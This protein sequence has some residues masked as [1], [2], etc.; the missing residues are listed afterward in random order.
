MA[1]YG[2]CRKCPNWVE[3]FSLFD[4]KRI[5]LLKIGCSILSGPL[6]ICKKQFV[7]KEYESIR[8]AI[9]RGRNGNSKMSHCIMKDPCFKNAVECAR[10]EHDVLVETALASLP[11]QACPYFFEH[12]II[13]WNNGKV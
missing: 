3:V 9:R 5:A 2:I 10:N 4:K 13:D 7:G 1:D 11:S 8:N 6:V 12:K